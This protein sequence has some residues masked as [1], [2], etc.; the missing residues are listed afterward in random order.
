MLKYRLANPFRKFQ[1]SMITFD[2]KWCI[3]YD[4]NIFWREEIR[5]RQ[6]SNPSG[7]LWLLTPLVTGKLSAIAH[8][9]ECSI[10]NCVLLNF[11]Y[12]TSS[13]HIVPEAQLW[14]GHTL[15]SGIFQWHG[16]PLDLQLNIRSGLLMSLWKSA[17]S[18]GILRG[19][20]C[21]LCPQCKWLDNS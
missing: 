15:F 2:L 14:N 13:W 7:E 16:G 12:E 18:I 10:V 8:S 6:L 19:Y 20:C 5:F 21:K 3:Y 17:T 4:H 11:P 1:R 9:K